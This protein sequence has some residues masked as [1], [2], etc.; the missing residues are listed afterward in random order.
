MNLYDLKQKNNLYY[1]KGLE[2]HQN[3]GQLTSIYSQTLHEL[4]LFSSCLIT[5][6][7]R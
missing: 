3:A 5:L 7:R 6:Q 4:D 2:S 1:A